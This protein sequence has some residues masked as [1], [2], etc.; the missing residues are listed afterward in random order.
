MALFDQLTVSLADLEKEERELDQTVQAA[1]M[2]G[3][4]QHLVRQR[5]EERM[6]LAVT[7]WSTEAKSTGVTPAVF[8]AAPTRSSQYASRNER[9]DR[10]ERRAPQHHRGPIGTPRRDEAEEPR[11]KKQMLAA[12]TEMTSAISVPAGTAAGQTTPRNVQR[13]LVADT[14]TSTPKISGG[15]RPRASPLLA[16]QNGPRL[17]AKLRLP[18]APRVSVARS[19]RTGRSGVV[20]DDDD[21]D[22]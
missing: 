16:P 12:R 17:G 19:G 6:Q 7:R 13:R 4:V 14:P 18:S 9:H 15:K 8:S 10:H 21:S 1:T 5:F 3:M 22:V 20:I 2:M 11:P